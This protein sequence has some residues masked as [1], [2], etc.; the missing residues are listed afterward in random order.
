MSFSK[1]RPQPI[2]I[3]T[4]FFVGAPPEVQFGVAATRHYGAGR[5]GLSLPVEDAAAKSLVESAYA[6]SRII[7]G[8]DHKQ[9]NNLHKADDRS[10]RFVVLERLPYGYAG[11][12]A[13]VKLI[14]HIQGPESLPMQKYFPSVFEKINP[15]NCVEISHLNS[16]H[17]NELIREAGLLAAL[18]VAY[19]YA[20]SLRDYEQDTLGQE[21]ELPKELERVEQDIAA[22]LAPTSSQGSNRTRLMPPEITTIVGMTEKFVKDRAAQ[23]GIP[24]VNGLGGP[25]M[26]QEARD[27]K[28]ELYPVAF[29]VEKIREAHQSGNNE[30]LNIYLDGI[31]YH[32]GVGWFGPMLIE[33]LGCPSD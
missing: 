14:H 29:D 24:S 25:S 26:V 32:G 10:E 12:F 11:L 1:E 9:I 27:T 22:F 6:A 28:T 7:D 2:T 19:G 31:E 4:D 23:L 8:S 21:L 5:S 13:T 20:L 17:P 33:Y 30:V 16:H 15:M 18:R 3:E